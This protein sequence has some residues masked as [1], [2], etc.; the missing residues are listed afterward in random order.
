M[1]V[2][3]I[4]P[5]V[6]RRPMDSDWKLHMAPPL[7]LLV[8]GAL[9]P[10]EYRVT[11]VDENVEPLRCDDQPDLVGITVKADTFKG[12]CRIAAEYRRRGI[13]VVMGGIHPTVCS[14][15]CAI[16]A[17]AVVMGPAER[18][19]PQLLADFELGQMRRFYRN[20]EA[21]DPVLTSPPRWEL[22]DVRVKPLQHT[23]PVCAQRNE[24]G[25]GACV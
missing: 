13:P 16:H 5:A 21:A 19:W 24:G 8:L 4:S 11:V 15:E 20:D 9:T 23:D 7:G 22:L 1:W 3:L 10:K 6:T 18:S 2:K 17:D 12:A 14:K 25:R